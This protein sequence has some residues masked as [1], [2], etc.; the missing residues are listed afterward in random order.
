MMKPY[1][2]LLVVSPLVKSLPVN[3]L[4]IDLTGFSCSES[5][6]YEMIEESSQCFAKADQ[7][8]DLARK[9]KDKALLAK[10]YCDAET[11]QVRRKICKYNLNCLKAK[12]C[13]NPVR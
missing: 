1:L 5:E 7:K 12:N 11:E 3:W 6:L 8:T 9:S 13:A 10:A 4:E 2:F